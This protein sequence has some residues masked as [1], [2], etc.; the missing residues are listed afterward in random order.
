MYIN[1]ANYTFAFF[2]GQKPNKSFTGNIYTDVL[3]KCICEK[4]SDGSMIP[5]KFRYN[6]DSYI[7]QDDGFNCGLLAC[8]S[9]DYIVHSKAMPNGTLSE[10]ELRMLRIKLSHCIVSS[11]LNIQNTAMNPVDLELINTM[12]K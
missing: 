9:A 11:S 7:I 5:E 4:A 8:L 12:I 1:K 10:D 3:I 2:N 6:F